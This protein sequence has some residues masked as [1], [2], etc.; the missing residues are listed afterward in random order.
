MR[1][2]MA[3]KRSDH[4]FVNFLQEEKQSCW[5]CVCSCEE[6]RY[7]WLG[8]GGGDRWSHEKKKAIRRQMYCQKKWK[9][10]SG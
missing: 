2:A 1:R 8:C 9:M 6:V 7:P 5:F 3:A 4:G 10:S